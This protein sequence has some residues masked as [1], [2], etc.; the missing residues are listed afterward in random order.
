MRRMGEKDL[1]IQLISV[2]ISTWRFWSIKSV[3]SLSSASFLLSN[4]QIML[5]LRTGF[6]RVPAGWVA[7]VWCDGSMVWGLG[8]LHKLVARF[9]FV[10]DYTTSTGHWYCSHYMISTH[11]TLRPYSKFGSSSRYCWTASRKPGF[12]FFFGGAFL[13]FR[14]SS[15]SP[16]C[17]PPY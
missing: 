2:V 14:F 7:W 5:L 15:A 9:K 10:D 11:Q 12:F 16:S 13:S 3:L 8:S 17:V 1:L 6:C 4:H